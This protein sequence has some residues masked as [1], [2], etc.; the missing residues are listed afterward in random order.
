MW[1]SLPAE[2]LQRLLPKSP[3]SGANGPTPTP[4]NDAGWNSIL[5]EMEEF[6]T[7]EDDYDGQ[8]AI[9]PTAQ[10]FESAAEL[11][12]AL[13]RQGVVAPTYVVPGVNGS[14]NF[15]WEQEGGV[16]VGIEV[17]GPYTADVFILG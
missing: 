16:S 14:M 10:T 9:A 15:D 4:T 7:L 6:R 8:G 11:A 13:R 17:V 12:R 3:A 5:T 1:S 2:V